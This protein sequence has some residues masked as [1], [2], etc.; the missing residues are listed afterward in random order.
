MCVIILIFTKDETYGDYLRYIHPNF[1]SRMPCA[2]YIYKALH[3]KA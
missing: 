2:V 3:N 1:E